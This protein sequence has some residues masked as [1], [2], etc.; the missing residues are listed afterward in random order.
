[1]PENKPG[2]LPQYGNADG[3]DV[4]DDGGENRPRGS[5][6]SEYGG[7]DEHDQYEDDEEAEPYKPPSFL[8][9][10]KL[11]R[12]TPRPRS[13]RQRAQPASGSEA[14]AKAV[15]LVT[16]RERLIAGFLGIFQFI[17]AVVF[18]FELRKLVV[19]PSKSPKISIAQARTD[20]INDHHLAPY[21]LV[22]NLI[23]GVGIVGA[24]FSKRRS[25]V[26]FTVLLAGLGLLSYGGGILGLVYLGVGIWLIF[27]AM[28]RKPATSAATAGGG[29]LGRPSARGSSR[30]SASS[31]A[32]GNVSSK[33]ESDRRELA[34]GAAATAQAVRTPPTASSRYTPPKPRKTGKSKSAPAPEPEKGR[35]A[36]WLRR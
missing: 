29:G 16:N 12:L 34:K 30:T 6:S 15:N 17:L 4:A 10:L 21:F 2:A 27:R 26:G 11:V 22:V 5:E 32:T 19:K 36:R 25:L 28:R 9:A 20:T 23:L 33:I 18:Y 13:S 8:E 14:D 1:M 3:G 7:S 24:T 35:L 31:R